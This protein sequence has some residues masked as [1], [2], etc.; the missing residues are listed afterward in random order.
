MRLITLILAQT[1]V[2]QNDGT[3]AA[4]GAGFDRIQASQLPVRVGDLALGC[5]LQFEEEEVGHEQT[6]E[7]K[8]LD[9]MGRHVV[10]LFGM[11]I[12]ATSLPSPT[13]H[14][15]FHFVYNLRDTMFAVKGT[16]RFVVASQGVDLGSIAIDVVVSG[17]VLES[18]LQSLSGAL[19]LGFGAFARGDRD[20]AERIFTGLAERFPGS[21]DAHNNLGFTLLARG[22]PVAALK[23]F[24]TA[25]RS[26]AQFTELVRANIATCHFLLG[27]RAD[28]METFH[29]L[30][31][32]PFRADVAYLFG[33]GRDGI[34]LVQLSGTAQFI[35][36]MALN[37][38]RIA[39]ATGDLRRAAQAR[40]LAQTGLLNRPDGPDEPFG[41]LLVEFE[42][43]LGQ[44]VTV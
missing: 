13:G 41:E 18:P 2:A 21:A 33:I 16:Y 44:G 34:R 14:D 20:E 8:L 26:G 37:E 31:S 29:A 12:L 10:P 23:S 25:L 3:F 30:L 36:L 9:P 42:S 19:A 7:I 35:G 17:A 4:I 6:I 27:N 43:D 40:S 38:G 5:K 22:E 32:E 15:R 39:L 11:G 1:A 28:A 24:E